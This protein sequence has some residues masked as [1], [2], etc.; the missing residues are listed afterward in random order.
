M[1]DNTPTETGSLSRR[2]ALKLGSAAAGGLLV[3][4]LA[5]ATGPGVAHA[6]AA[7]PSEKP[8]QLPVKDIERI[9]GA[10]GMLSNCVFN[11]EIDRTD[12]NNVHNSFG[13][14]IKPSFQVNGNLVFQ[15]LG[16]QDR[17]GDDRNGTAAFNGDLPFLARELQPSLDQML[18]HGLTFQ[19]MH[20]HFYDWD[21]MVWFMHFRAT[22][23]PRT[24]AKG[25][26]AVL[27][28]TATPLPQQSPSNPKTPLGTQRLVKIIGET[29]TVGSDG[30]V[31]FEVPRKNP[32]RLDGT[33]ISPHLNVA[34]TVAFEPLGSKTAVAVDFG[35][36]SAEIQGL[37]V[38]MR[39]MGWQVGCLYNQ[40]TD[41]YPQLYFSH[42]SRPATP[43]PWPS[44]CAEAWTGSTSN[45]T[46]SAGPRIPRNYASLG[47]RHRSRH[48]LA[49]RRL[50][51]PR[52]QRLHDIR[53]DPP[54]Q[55]VRQH[56]HP[57]AT[58][59]RLPP[60][61]AQHGGISDELTNPL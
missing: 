40:E 5:S 24:I 7:S 1:S 43:T 28:A 33:Q 59:W 15:S 36:V 16:D 25:V 48:Q 11:I 34:T 41:E 21:P 38:L 20:Q 8:R 30:V 58:I 23:D 53:P 22:G 6:S 60:N 12:L 35:M 31:S 17:D 26:A 45:P 52:R 32:I 44:R 61:P 29:P 51:R 47:R 27:S 37:T 19:A 39:S 46:T 13:V 50:R 18:K 42:Q 56:R 49:G 4:G 57:P 9:I 54:Q 2:S 10:Q 14:P 3:A 55:H